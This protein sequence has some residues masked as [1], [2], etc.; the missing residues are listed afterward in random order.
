MDQRT[1]YITGDPHFDMCRKTERE[2]AQ[3]WKQPPRQELSALK[4]ANTF[5]SR[6]P[7]HNL[8]SI[9]RNFTAN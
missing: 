6:I 2:T 1:H 9:K 7:P 8:L 4:L 5:K 3:L